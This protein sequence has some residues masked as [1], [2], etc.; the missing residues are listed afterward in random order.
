MNYFRTKMTHPI[1]TIVSYQSFLHCL[2]LFFMFMLRFTSLLTYCKF[3]SVYKLR[4]F[5]IIKPT[6][7]INFS[8]LFWNKTLH[9]SDSSSVRHQEFFTVHSNGICHTGLLTAARSC[10]QTRMTYTIVVYSEKLL[11][12]HRGTVRNM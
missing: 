4:S 5:L 12:T 9:V 7:C 8:N 10:Q 6:R 3:Q 1:E 2:L 11:M